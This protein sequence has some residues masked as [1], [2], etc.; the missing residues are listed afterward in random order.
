MRVGYEF[1]DHSV[2]P[3]IRAVLCGAVSLAPDSTMRDLLF[4]A[5]Q[6]IVTLAK[7]ARPGGV[8][9]VIAESRLLKHQLIISGRC[10]RRAPPLTTMDCVSCSD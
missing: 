2:R 7:L 8:R 6:L 4:L 5:V 3:R 9:S 10:R 1:A